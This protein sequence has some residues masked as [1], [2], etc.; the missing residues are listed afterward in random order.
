MSLHQLL[1]DRR[2]EIL[3]GFIQEVREQDLPP[4]DLTRSALADHIPTFLEQICAELSAGKDGSAGDDA[5]EVQVTARRHGEQRWNVGCDV[6]GPRVR[7]VRQVILEAGRCPGTPLNADEG[8]KLASYI[9]VGVSGA[10]A[11]YVRCREEQLKSRQGD[12]EFL[13]DRSPDRHGRGC[14]ES[15][16]AESFRRRT[17]ETGRSARSFPRR[18]G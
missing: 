6:V 10:I 12:L 8:D 11:E 18:W 17:V 5:S 14:S 13:T 2:E 16:T 9:E 15:P 1:R 7:G 3:A 4:R